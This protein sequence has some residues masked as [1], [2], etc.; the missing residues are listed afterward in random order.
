MKGRGRDRELRVADQLRSD[1]CIVYRL[2]WGNADL[3]AFKAG[4]RPLLVQV[5]ST[6]GGP[7]ERFG[8]ADRAALQQ[9]AVAAGAACVL[10][11]WPPRRRLEWRTPDQWP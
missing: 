4:W 1:G 3:V 5:K 8:P 10:A 2:A 6:S 7:Y 11:W 9:E